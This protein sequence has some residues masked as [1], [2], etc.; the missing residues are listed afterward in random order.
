M[1][2]LRNYLFF[3]HL[4]AIPPSQ[5]PFWRSLKF[6]QF[7]NYLYDQNL[8]AIQPN[9]SVGVAAR[10]MDWS[11]YLFTSQAQ[12][13]LK[14]YKLKVQM[15][16]KEQVI[17]IVFAVLKKLLYLLRTSRNNNDQDT[18]RKC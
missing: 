16:L 18:L 2:T 12:A 14:S 1:T 8:K 4:R 7:V 9:K 10:L 6:R 17:F 3:H 5:N 15:S 11:R 13:L